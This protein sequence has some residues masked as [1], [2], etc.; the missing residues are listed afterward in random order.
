MKFSNGVE[1]AA[2]G[3]RLFKGAMSKS[4]ILALRSRDLGGN[5]MKRQW[6]GSLSLFFVCSCLAGQVAAQGVLLVANDD[7]RAVLPRPQPRPEPVPNS[8]K[9]REL[10]VKARIEDQVAQVQVAQSF[11]NTGSQQMEVQFVFPLPYDGA[12]DRLTLLVDGKEFPARLL[13]AKEARRIYE[14]YIRK[15]QDPALLEWMGTGMFRTAVFPVPAGAERKVT[16]RYNQLLRKDHD[17]TDFLFPLGTAKYTSGAVE[18]VEIEASIHSSIEIKNIYSPTHPITVERGDDHRAMVTYTAKNQ[19]PT[20]DFRLFFD[21][22][23]GKLGAGVI[24]FRPSEDEDGYFLLLASPQIEKSDRDPLQKDV[25]CVVDCSGSMTGKKIEQAKEAL[26]FVIN[27]LRE[28][29]RFNMVAYDSDVE[30]FQPELQPYSDSTRHQALGFIEGLYAGGGTN[31]D[32]ALTTAL[33]MLS[34]SSSPNFMIFLTD[35][36]PT[37]GETNESKIVQNA[38]RN[39]QAKVRII[40]FGVGYDVN[41]R[42]L[43]RIARANH[44]QSEY[45]RPD[46]DIEVHVSRLYTTIAAPAMTEV[47]VKFEFDDQRVEDGQ[48][49]TRVYPK[50]V[51]D[52]FQGEQFVLVGR[53]KKYGAANIA[54][55]GHVGGEQQK[56]EFSATFTEHSGDQKYGFVEKLWAMRRIGEII[57]E[58]DLNGKND[59]LVKE[60]V[61][62]STRHGILTPYTSYLADDD[63]SARDLAAAAIGGG[64]GREKSLSLVDRLQ[65]ANGIGGFSQRSLKNSLRRAN[66]P[67]ADSP[68][69]EFG[70][71]RGGARLQIVGKDK[72]VDVQQ[73]V[74]NIGNQTLYRRGDNLWIATNAADI[75]LERDKEKIKTIERFSDEWFELVHGNTQVENDILARQRDGEELLMRFRGHACLVK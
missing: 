68:V 44:G 10:S 47:T 21:V 69:A 31:I 56:F 70:G 1:L 73:I 11:V 74:R 3:V 52:L 13:A 19:V 4:R 63:A 39:N 43:D 38:G 57:D 28:G 50:E 26:K 24:S 48:P 40:N 42:L 25:V 9:I 36:L 51:G 12:I 60:L 75:D 15:N 23:A 30:S 64:R 46:E 35:G 20:S 37:I 7:G 72:S 5:Q 33:G 62:L 27:N 65:E 41:S 32:G 66:R 18:K 58:I 67:Q 6:V 34:D 17:L 45:V 61:A 71:S 8:Y 16:L 59:E 14:G 29:D 2:P 53:Y 49:V 54:I 22:A 55:A